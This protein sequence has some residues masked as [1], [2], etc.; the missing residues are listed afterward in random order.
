M[1]CKKTYFT[2][3]GFVENPTYKIYNLKT[4]IFAY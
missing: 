2:F 3:E 4:D 1:L